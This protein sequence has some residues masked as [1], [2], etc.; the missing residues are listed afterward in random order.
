MTHTWSTRP[1]M[2]CPDGHVWSQ[3][4]MESLQVS[5][6][7]CRERHMLIVTRPAMPYLDGRMEQRLDGVPT[8]VRFALC[9]LQGVGG[10]WAV[11]PSILAH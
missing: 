9:S 5:C 1:V 11:T 3:G 10:R 6:S 8:G 7:V 4:Q 2:P